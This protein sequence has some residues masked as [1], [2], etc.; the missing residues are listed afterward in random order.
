VPCVMP[1]TGRRRPNTVKG[2]DADKEI[3]SLKIET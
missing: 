2:D 3:S 1:V